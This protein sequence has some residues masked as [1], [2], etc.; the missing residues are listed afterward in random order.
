LTEPLDGALQSSWDA[1]LPES[2]RV[3]ER[4]LREK[5]DAFTRLKP[6]VVGDVVKVPCLVPHSLQHGVR[7]IEFQTPVYERKILSF[8][9]KVLTQHEW[10]TEDALA[11]VKAGPLIDHDFELIDAD[12]GC[13]L[14]NIVEFSDFSVFR[15]RLQPGA[16]FNYCSQDYAVLVGVKGSVHCDKVLVKAEQACIMPAILGQVCMI[17]NDQEEAILLIARPAELKCG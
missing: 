1:A 8:A 9:Q 11:V 13:Y 2:L 15:L 10:D 6:L 4:A 16:R 5:M 17:N 14:E 3:S 7:T 12:V